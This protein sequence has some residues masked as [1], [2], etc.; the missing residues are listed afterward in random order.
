MIIGSLGILTLVGLL[1]VW[2]YENRVIKQKPRT[3]NLMGYTFKR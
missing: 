3:I 1:N 2:Y